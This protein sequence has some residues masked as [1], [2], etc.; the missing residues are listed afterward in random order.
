LPAG[1]GVGDAAVARVTTGGADAIG[2]TLVAGSLEFVTGCGGGGAAVLE[3]EP[4]PAVDVLVP[5]ESGVM[6]VL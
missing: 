6:E 1:R 4:G 3:A 5:A 2:T